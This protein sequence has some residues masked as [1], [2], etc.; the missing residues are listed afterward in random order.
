MTRKTLIEVQNKHFS[1][2]NKK[3]PREFKDYVEVKLAH[4][5]RAEKEIIES[6]LIKY[7]GIFYD[8]EDN[9]FKSTN[10]VVHK[11]ET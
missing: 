5:S 11:I 7:A 10:I 2:S 9:D 3:I 1:G 4:L 6:V 8:D